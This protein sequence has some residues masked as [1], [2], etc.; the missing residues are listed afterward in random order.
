MALAPIVGL[1]Q[2]EGQKLQFLQPS[3]SLKIGTIIAFCITYSIAT[4]FMALRYFQAF[5]LTKK[6]EID[7]GIIRITLRLAEHSY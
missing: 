6:I 7:L 2:P 1:N 3:M 4:I 5:K